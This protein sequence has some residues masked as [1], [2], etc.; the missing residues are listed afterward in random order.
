[1]WRARH[2]LR[3]QLTAADRL[4]ETSARADPSS[5]DVSPR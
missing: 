4:P 2:R 5:R 3:D 1:M